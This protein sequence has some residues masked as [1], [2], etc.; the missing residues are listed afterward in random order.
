MWASSGYLQ[1]GL[2]LDTTAHLS[3]ERAVLAAA[4]HIGVELADAPVRT[5]PLGSA[6]MAVAVAMAI[7]PFLA[8][9]ASKSALRQRKERVA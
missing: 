8:N 9:E 5:T 2:Q 3:P 1:P 4:G 6:D 7:L